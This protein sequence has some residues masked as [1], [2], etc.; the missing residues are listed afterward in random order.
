MMD[1]VALQSILMTFGQLDN[2][3]RDEISIV[4][5]SATYYDGL[6]NDPINGY[7]NVHDHD[8]VAIDY[9]Y[10]DAIKTITMQFAKII[11]NNVILKPRMVITFGYD[12]VS[13]IYDITIEDHDGECLMVKTDRPDVTFPMNSIQIVAS[14]NILKIIKSIFT[15]MNLE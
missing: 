13:E 2:D 9:I 3:M 6:S 12:A 7:L 10:K 14:H 1:V 5:H 11:F 8:S 4:I 15:E